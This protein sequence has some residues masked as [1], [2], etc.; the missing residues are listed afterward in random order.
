MMCSTA[1]FAQGDVFAIL[2][3]EATGDAAPEAQ[4]ANNMMT[5]ALQ[6]ESLM[7][8][9]ADDV[10]RA[11]ATHEGAC[12]QSLLACAR[13][14]GAQVKATRV[15][16]SSLWAT[17]NGTWELHLTA[18][19]L[20]SGAEPAPMQTF[21]TA[22][23]SEVGAIAERE[24]LALI[25][26]GASGWL[27]VTLQ[28]AANA[29]LLVDGLIVDALPLAADKRALA[30]RHSVEVRAPELK[31][32][33]GN[34]EVAPGVVT[35]LALTV[36]GGDIVVVD[37]TATA[38][39]GPDPMVSGGIAS[40]VVGVIADGQQATAQERFIA[41]GAP[42]DRDARSGWQTVAFASS[43]AG[44]VLIGFGVALTILGVVTE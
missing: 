18:V 2:P 31:S 19:D 1:S 28:G 23:R 6:R 26:R 15:I 5:R 11:M 37:D 25:G 22:Q 14:V 34:I 24:A 21:V 38:D 30:G 32:W 7:L 29:S 40:V 16:V 10:T 42:A 27:S 8:V 17:A 41:D 36:V 35:K 9:S 3:T 39:S 20:A 12:T 13:L 44:A 33:Q 43:T 4:L